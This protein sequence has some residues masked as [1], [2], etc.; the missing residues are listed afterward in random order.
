MFV[1]DTYHHLRDRVGYMQR[2]QQTLKPGG[3]LV[4]PVGPAHSVQYLTVIEKQAQ[5]IPVLVSEARPR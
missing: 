5:D 2:L 3:R 4:I 1:A